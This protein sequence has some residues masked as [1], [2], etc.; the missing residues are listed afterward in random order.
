LQQAGA[1]RSQ[2]QNLLRDAKAEKALLANGAN[3]SPAAQLKVAQI[4]ASDQ[5]QGNADLAKANQLTGAAAA[6]QAKAVQEAATN[7]K[8][9][10]KDSQQANA[11]LQQAAKLRTTGQGLLQDAKAEKAVLASLKD[12]GSKNGTPGGG[13]NSPGQTQPGGSESPSTPGQTQP[14]GSESPSSPG[15]T[16]TPGG[17]QTASPA[18][19]GGGQT[20]SPA[21][22]AATPSDNNT[23]PATAATQAPA[24]ATADPAQATT[25]Q[26]PTTAAQAPATA[27]QTPATATQTALNATQ[28][29]APQTVSVSFKALSLAWNQDGG[30]VVR[31]ADALPTATT[32]AIS[33]CNG[34]FGSCQQAAAVDAGAFGC[35]AVASTS[36]HQL[37]SATGSSL[38]EVTTSLQQ[39]LESMG[40][41]GEVQYSGCNSG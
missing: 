31:I 41:K 27:A 22:S 20:A 26:A 21:P 29:P 13:S 3:A 9:A 35:L 30:W 12:N 17:G 16:Q 4:A 14:G 7:P 11:D 5:K 8:Q 10:L 37:F 34:Q 39:K 28:A 18:S 23:A 25:A 38:D 15:Q 36:E 40:A 6:L 32:D 24:P 33:T 19:P 2:G 1:L